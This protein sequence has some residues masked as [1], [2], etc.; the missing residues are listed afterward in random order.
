MNVKLTEFIKR[1][2]T[3]YGGDFSTSAHGWAKEPSPNFE[4]L[5]KLFE[6]R[7]P[8]PPEQLGVSDYVTVYLSKLGYLHYRHNGW[9]SRRTTPW[10]IHS[11]DLEMIITRNVKGFRPYLK[12]DYL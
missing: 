12:L 11:T 4:E 1:I 5:T 3:E 8:L 2:V 9:S 6:V 10:T 7:F